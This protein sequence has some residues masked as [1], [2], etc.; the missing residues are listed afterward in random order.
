VVERFRRVRRTKVN[1]HVPAKLVGP[2]KTKDRR[3]LTAIIGMMA[4]AVLV[5]I[6][7]VAL[8]DFPGAPE[9]SEDK[10]LAPPEDVR[11]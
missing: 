4:V 9:G 7:F 8:S 1:E 6:A 2:P 11:R 5:L 3:I 10:S